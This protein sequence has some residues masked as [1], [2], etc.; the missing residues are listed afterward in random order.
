MCPIS[1]LLGQSAVSCEYAAASFVSL[2]DGFSDDRNASWSAVVCTSWFCSHFG[3]W[4]N[5]A[6]LCEPCPENCWRAWLTSWSEA[7][8]CFLA[9]YW[10]MAS[11]WI[12]RHQPL[13]GEGGRDRALRLRSTPCWDELLAEQG[14]W[15]NPWAPRTTSSEEMSCPL[16]VA[17]VAPELPHPAR[18]RSATNRRRET[19]RFMKGESLPAAVS[20]IRTRSR[21]L[22][23]RSVDELAQ[24][25]DE[26]VRHLERGHADRHRQ[27]AAVLGDR[28]G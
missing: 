15:P 13:G 19:V 5:A 2:T 1:F 28:P 6:A 22:R 27:L 18:A 14:R 3:S 26:R 11:D 17:A 10:L 8:T 23:L 24:Q 12:E 25:V 9:A 7:F 16:T 20:A 4:L 21:A